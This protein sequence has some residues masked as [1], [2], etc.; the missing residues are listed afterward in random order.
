MITAVH[1]LLYSDDPAATRAFLRD[2]IG[3]PSVDGD[4]SGDWPIFGTGPSELGVHPVDEGAGAAGRHHQ[5]ALMCDDVA[6]TRADLEGKG[7]TFVGEIEDHGYGQVTFVE[8]PGIDPIQLY[9]PRHPTAY[10]R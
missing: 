2:V 10:D 5:I 1:C 6:A 4:P 9:Q 7:A 3:W 8:V